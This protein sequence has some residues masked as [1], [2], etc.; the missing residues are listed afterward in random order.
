MMLNKLITNNVL[1]PTCKYYQ[2]YN[3]DFWLYSFK[4]SI[5]NDFAQAVLLPILKCITTS[6]KNQYYD[7]SFIK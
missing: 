2:D 6:S 3:N 7:F 4:S 1:S 5:V